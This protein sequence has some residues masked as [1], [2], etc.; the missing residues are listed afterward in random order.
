MPIQKNS[1]KETYIPT[2]VPL[3]LTLKKRGLG[4]GQDHR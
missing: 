3:G 1:I 4:S 2:L